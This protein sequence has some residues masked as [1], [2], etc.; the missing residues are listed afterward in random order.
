MPY[1]VDSCICSCRFLGFLENLEALTA[2]GSAFQQGDSAWRAACFSLVGE[3]F[4]YRS[5]GPSQTFVLSA[6]ALWTS[7]CVLFGLSVLSIIHSISDPSSQ[8]P[9]FWEYMQGW[10]CS[11]SWTHPEYMGLVQGLWN[12]WVNQS[13]NNTIN[14]WEKLQHKRNADYFQLYYKT[15]TCGCISK[16]YGFYPLF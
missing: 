11:A 10:G 1:G 7:E 2:W 6:W 15:T 9:W 3:T 16:G 14:A 12:R 4:L 8:D 13:M 5:S